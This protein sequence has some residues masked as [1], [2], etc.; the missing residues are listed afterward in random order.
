[1]EEL[2]NCLICGKGVCPVCRPDDADAENDKL[3][4]S[5]FKFRC[6]QIEETIQALKAECSKM[7]ETTLQEAAIDKLTKGI[8]LNDME[9]NTL[10]GF[11][12][13]VAL[14]E[15]YSKE[16][17]TSVDPKEFKMVEEPLTILEEAQ[18]L[19][20]GDRQDAYGPPTKSFKEISNIWNIILKDKLGFK[21]ITPQDVAL[22]M[23]GLKLC[24]QANKHSRDNLVDLAAYAHIYQLLEEDE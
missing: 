2:G 3:Y 22:M 21:Y 1:M 14:R 11:N 24:R 12:I 23:A 7:K 10:E 18:K 20:S 19:V 15:F 16:T 6:F 13:C 17:K 5:S 8:K 9:V 4:H